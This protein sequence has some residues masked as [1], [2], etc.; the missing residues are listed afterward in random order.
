MPRMIP[1]ICVENPSPGENRMF[2]VLDHDA[3]ADWVVLCGL[4]IAPW[5]NNKQTE[6][7]FLVIM[8]DR[9]ILC[10][11]VKGHA[12][13][14]YIGGVWHL[15][16][17]RKSRDPF[18]QADKA[19]YA[20]INRIQ[21]SLPSLASV[22]IQR[23]VVFPIA[24]FNLPTNI[25]VHPWEFMDGPAFENHVANG[26]IAT[27]LKTCIDKSNNLQRRS[28]RQRLT[29]N[30]INDLIGFLRPTIRN[31][32]SFK[33]QREMQQKELEQKLNVQQ[34]PVLN[35]LKEN[36]RI[37]V[38]GGAGT[39]KTWIA[40]EAAKRLTSN[41]KRVGLFCHQLLVGKWIEK[42]VGV[43]PG[44]VNGQLSAKI[45]KMM[46]LAGPDDPAEYK[47]WTEKELPVLALKKL[48][49]EGMGDD[50]MFDALVIDEA[51]DLLS[52]ENWWKLLNRLIRGGL[53]NGV[54]VLLGDFKHQVLMNLDGQKHIR[55]NLEWL[56][57]ECRP[58]Y[59]KLTHN[60]RNTAIIGNAARDLARLDGSE[61]LYDGFLR[62]AGH[63]RDFRHRNYG[64]R[65]EQANLLAE[66]ISYWRDQGYDWGD[67]TILSAEEDGGVA[68]SFR[69][70]ANTAENAEIRQRLYPVLEKD[71]GLRFGHV[72]DFKGL[73]NKVIILTDV[74]LASESANPELRK[75]LFYTGLTRSL[76]GASVL[77]TQQTRAW[78]LKA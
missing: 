3:P 7:D 76:H 70:L 67:I 48:E 25:S 33:Q 75:N 41:Y 62:P 78:M 23:C 42:Q 29:D 15:G 32:P 39:G 69:T 4:D 49:E 21:A 9:G 13:I 47:Q 40:M 43:F 44:M 36:Q 26:T 66:E 72:D 34:A 45:Q 6:I 30:Q 38:D 35:L 2:P 61:L 73:E 31:E 56:R 11:E 57:K 59:W 12:E 55:N 58:V 22:P 16:R 1:N 65:Q 27:F 51:Q 37:L 8:P 18:K 64:N 5:N 71:H 17:D 68:A 28:L 63:P 14:Q 54:W 60:C 10:I 50:C 77:W 46:S 52:R 19:K 74:D 20:F 53:N 24:S